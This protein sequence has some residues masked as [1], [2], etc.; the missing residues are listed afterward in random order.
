MQETPLESK[1]DPVTP[2]WMTIVIHYKSVKPL[3]FCGI[4]IIL[5]ISCNVKLLI[6]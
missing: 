6:S 2:E 1:N 3:I 4:P 5:S